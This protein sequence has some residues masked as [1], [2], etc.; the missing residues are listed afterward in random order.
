[1]SASMYVFMICSRIFEHTELMDY[2][3]FMTKSSDVSS[4]R[5]YEDDFM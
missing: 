1:M 2:K 5:A 4:A 3:D